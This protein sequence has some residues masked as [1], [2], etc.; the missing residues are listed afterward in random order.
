MGEY[1]NCPA[2]VNGNVTKGIGYLLIQANT[3]G[4]ML[5]TI[6]TQFYSEGNGAF[7]L[8]DPNPDLAMGDA[9]A[10]MAHE[11]G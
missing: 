8:F 1:N 4:R 5:T 10:N 7:M 9:V 3:D 11:I 2:P 6:G